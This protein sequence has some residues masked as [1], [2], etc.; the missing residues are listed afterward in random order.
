MCG[1][2]LDGVSNLF[3]VIDIVLSI[4]TLAKMRVYI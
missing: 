1:N 3:P 4:N 2:W